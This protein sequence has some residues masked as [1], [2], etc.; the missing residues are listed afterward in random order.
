MAYQNGVGVEWMD[1]PQSVMLAA[2]GITYRRLDAAEALTVVADQG[3]PADVVVSP[4]GTALVIAGADGHG[5][6]EVVSL[7][8]DTS[9]RVPIGEG[10]SA[11]PVSMA[12]DGTVAVL[13]SSSEMSPYLGNDFRLH[14]TLAA[15]HL[16]TGELREY[17]ITDANAAAIAPDASRIVVD[18]A[19]GLKTVDAETGAVRDLG[20]T[21]GNGWLGD[22][23]WA[24]DGDRFA[25]LDGTTLRVIDVSGGEPVESAV[26]VDL[27]EYG[28]VYGWRDDETVLMYTADGDNS[29]EFAWVDVATGDSETFSTYATGITGAAIATLDVARDLVPGWEVGPRPAD[30][31]V[32]Q[33]IAAAALAVPVALIV[34]GLT[35]RRRRP[36]DPAPV[37]RV[38][39]VPD[40]EPVDA[41]AR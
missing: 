27:L 17:D 34:W 35:P 33:L 6:V 19:T 21:V 13:L 7:A 39:V 8:D 37:E 22:D 20:L 30:R 41:L 10:R 36:G 12:A 16:G 26:P 28:S 4:D 25:L 5:F 31:G 29:G 38:E 15:L 40:P 11:I 9:R 32:G 24:P 2:D 14:G 3:D 18:T 1:A 23:A